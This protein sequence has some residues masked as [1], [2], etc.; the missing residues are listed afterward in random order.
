MLISSRQ[1]SLFV[2]LLNLKHWFYF[3]LFPLVFGKF[4]RSLFRARRE[5]STILNVY[6]RPLFVFNSTQLIRFFVFVVLLSFCISACEIIFTY[7]RLLLANV[8]GVIVVVGCYLRIVL[9]SVAENL[10]TIRNL[11]KNSMP[12]NN[13]YYGIMGIFICQF[14]T[15]ESNP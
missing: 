13:I 10:H 11:H 14:I 9:R 12:Y 6:T 3:V 7:R 5:H 8:F 1:N 4:Q 2:L 15:Y